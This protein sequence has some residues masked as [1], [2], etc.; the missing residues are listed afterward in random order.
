MISSWVTE[1]APWRSAVP[2]QSAPVSPP[3]MM[4]TC[5]PS[6]LIGGRCRSPSCTRLAGT[7]YSIA[8]W[9]PARSR[10]GAGRSRPRVD[11]PASSTAS[12]VDRS[13]LDGDVDPD[14]D[15]G[16]ELRALRPHLLQAALEDALLH[17]ELGDPVAQQAP[18]AVGPL[19]HDDV[20]AGAGQLL[21][22]G[23]PGRPG[24]D[25]GDLLAGA[26]PGGLRHGPA[27]GEGAVGDLH[28]DLLDGD[29]V[30]VD[31]EHAGGLAGRR[32]QPPGELREVVGRVQP[33]ARRVPVVLVDEVV[34]LRDEVPERA[35]VVAEGDAA[36]H[37]ARRLV[38][39]VLR[40]E[41]LVDLL[42]VADADVD[43]AARRQ[44]AVVL[45]E[46]GGVG[47]GAAP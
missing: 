34:P 35:A 25:D 46:A 40:G 15:A 42:P 43:R 32:A 5:L 44:L 31:A 33:L 22:G 6:A 47:H 39:Q 1:A 38:V 3:P 41:V 13:S 8:R 36:V 12:Y 37:A 19:E 28:L 18:D 30:G 27:L 14:V 45:E 11:P 20:V 4:T 29:R 10:P 2:R 17:L 26:L 7:R 16:A 23:E 9:M 21:R 24:A